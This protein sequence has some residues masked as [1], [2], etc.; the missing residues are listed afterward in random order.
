M[1]GV[2]Q[3]DI[4]FLIG[5][6]LLLGSLAERKRLCP[7]E[8]TWLKPDRTH[9][10]GA[11]ANSIAKAIR[12]GKGF[13]NPFQRESGPTAWRPPVM[14]YL[15]TC[16][17]AITADSPKGVIELVALLHLL[18]AFCTGLIVLSESRQLNCPIIGYVILTLGYCSN[19]HEVFQKTDDTALSL[20][21]ANGIWI[22]LRNTWYG[23]EKIGMAIRW[24]IFGGISALSNPTLGGLWA[25]VT[26]IR[27]AKSP[28][29]FRSAPLAIAAICSILTV[30]PWM[31]RNTIA[32]GE[33]IPIKSNFYYE[34]WQS[35]CQGTT[36]LISPTTLSSHP[37]LG[38]SSRLRHSQIGEVKFVREK[39]NEVLL[40][41]SSTPFEYF[42]RVK[43]RFF[44][45][46]L[47]YQPYSDSEANNAALLMHRCVYPLTLV[48]MLVLLL[49]PSEQATAPAVK[50]AMAILCLGLAPYILV[51]YYPRYAAPLCGM[52]MLIWL[53]CFA[54]IRNFFYGKCKRQLRK[55]NS[56]RPGGG[57][58][59]LRRVGQ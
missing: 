22:G 5:L 45:A 20:F 7:D 19:F 39:K 29:I 41:I 35:Q 52:K 17:Y 59:V 32:L 10:L 34:L 15:L 28:Q 26:L 55:N 49:V 14:V 16:C 1:A 31:I 56:S 33:W 6:I 42:R 43:N 37:W 27:W 51:S 24:G 57:E 8:L 3:G 25:G 21:L 53:Y 18:A 13:S 2:R 4:A 44:A 54:A 30:T 47:V 23:T 9:H 12:R 36:G 50:S 11:E 58:Q 40:S 38:G 46:T 48:S